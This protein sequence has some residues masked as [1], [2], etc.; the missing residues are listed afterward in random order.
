LEASLMLASHVLLLLKVP[1]PRVFE[2]IG[3]IRN[4]RYAMLQQ[5]FR[6]DDPRRARNRLES[7]ER[8]HTVVLPPGAYAVGRS[9]SD[10]Q[11]SQRSTVAITGIRREGILGQQPDD[12]TV[13]REGDIVVLYGTA[14]ALE[15][16]EKLLL[17]G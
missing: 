6:T 7:E 5:L 9:V 12:S 4:N 10:M 2:T 17:M 13:F 3:D 1:V 16:G 8:L 11:L 15:H 14:D